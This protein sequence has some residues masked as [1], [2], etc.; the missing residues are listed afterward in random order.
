MRSLLSCL[1]LL[2]L[3]LGPAHAASGAGRF[4]LEDMTWME[5]KER[6]KSGATVAIIPTGG[7]E[8]NGPQ[9]VTGKH[10]FIVEYTA[11]EIAR[12]LGNAVVAPVLAY[13]PE[14]RIAPPEGHMRFPGTISISETAFGAVVEDAARSLKQHG[15]TVIALLGDHGGSQETL[16]AVANRLSD[17]WA[18]EGVEV[19]NVTSYYKTG[20]ES[21][22]LKSRGLDVKNPS[23]HAGFSDT[24]EM[25]AVHPEGVRND[26]RAAYGEENF[27]TAGAAGDST[28]AGATHGR[29][30]LTMRVNAAIKQIEDASS[31][32]R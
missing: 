12:G 27:T 32:R 25:L 18:G 15:F 22:W 5:L 7:T 8:Q 4:F 1:P 24:S 21:G 16:T 13:V 26:L 29:A 2:F 14:G 30:L 17:E 20:A 28:Q 10:N 19:L 23:A 11:G 3:A 6:M 31:S 9:L